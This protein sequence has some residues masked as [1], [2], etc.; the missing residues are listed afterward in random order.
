MGDKTVIVADGRSGQVET[1]A[2]GGLTE[3]LKKPRL[4]WVL[5]YQLRLTLIGCAGAL[6]LIWAPWSLALMG[7][8]PLVFAVRKAAELERDENNVTRFILPLIGVGFVIFWFACWDRVLDA[9]WPATTHILGFD[10]P[11]RLTW[12]FHLAIRLLLSTLPVVFIWN[13]KP[14][15]HRMEAEIVDPFWP[16]PIGT[17]KPESGPAY[18]GQRLRSADAPDEPEVVERIIARPIP[19]Q[20][21][22]GQYLPP[23]PVD[24]NPQR[25]ERLAKDAQGKMVM[26]PMGGT[27]RLVDLLRFATLAPQIGTSFS[28][29]WKE[30][31]WEHS[32]WG[33]V[34]DIW[35]LYG[36]TSRRE[37]R[38]KVMLLIDAKIAMAKLAQSLD[39]PTLWAGR[40][41][42]DSVG[43]QTEQE[44]NS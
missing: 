8:L 42:Q 27:V 39:S 25:V 40:T 17:R 16:P 29:V 34:V 23:P 19:V 7:I 21:T 30:R 11:L 18:P 4:Q 37:E 22:N 12:H 6:F 24:M 15:A 10:I 43:E 28:G 1:R 33:D 32:Y 41:V 9:L 13:Y 38:K 3:E 31:G 2:A 26:A 14:L 36:F 5:L 20:R 35:N 44:Q